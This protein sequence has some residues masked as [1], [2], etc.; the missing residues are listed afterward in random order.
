MP[1]QNFLQIL[2]AELVSFVLVTVFS[3]LIGLSQRKLQQKHEGDKGEITTFGTD[4]TF[5]FI[6]ILG[7]ILYILDKTNLFLF[8]GGGFALVV[9]FGLNYYGKIRNHDIY[10]LTTILIGL[11]TYCLA[12]VVITQ[13]M[14]FSLMVV[15]LILMLSEM[16]ST[17]KQFANKMRNDELITLSKFLIISGIVLPILPKNNIIEGINLTPYSVW[18]ATVVVSGIS[19]ASYL[20][21]RYVF[22]ES[23]IFVSGLLGGL[24]SS[25]ATI[26]ILA[27]ESKTASTNELPKFTGAM[28]IAKSMMFLKFLILIFIF[29]KAIFIQIYPYLLVMVIV[30]AVVSW[31]FYRK[32]NGKAELKITDE[33]AEEKEYKNPLEFKV[34]LIFAGLFVFFTLLTTYTVRYVG[35][36]GVTALSLLSGF[37]DITPFILNLLQNIGEIQP[38]IV[39]MSILL[40]MISNTIVTMFYAYFFSGQ[41]KELKKML[42]TSFL[43]VISL[44]VLL[45]GAAYII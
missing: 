12:P 9:F 8:F 19:Y 29:S 4:R 31:F 14:W 10:G 25:T 26:A 40:A 39:I 20:L 6:G 18:L 35:N 45:L 17:F 37:S 28:I 32:K 1:M 7:Y 15:V 43:I 16:K 33:N 38:K 34:A 13:P 27:K 41:R 22:K 3:F 5:T 2:P 36:S 24:Y 44:N 11:I 21:K 42:F 30:A 23:G